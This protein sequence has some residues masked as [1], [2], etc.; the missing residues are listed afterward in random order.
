MAFKDVL[1]NLFFENEIEET[2]KRND[3]LQPFEKEWYCDTVVTLWQYQYA[4]STVASLLSSYLVNVDWTV[5]KQGER[6]KGDM[7][8]RLNYAPNKK[9]TSA[10]FFGKL[11][12]KLI[13]DREALIVEF[14][15]GQLFVA[16]QYEINEK[17]IKNS[18]FTNIMVGEY[19]SPLIR[20]FTENRDCIYVK[21]PLNKN[22]DRI[23]EM[24]NKNYG[25]ILALV[26]KGARKAMGMKLDLQLDAN[27]KNKYDEQTLRAL[28]DT[29]TKLMEKENALFIS[30]KGETLAD[31]TEKQ[32]GS[33]VQ[34]VLDLAKN[35][36]EVNQEILKT[37]GRAFGITQDIMTGDISTA[38]DDNYIMTMTQFT[39]PIVRMLDQKFTTY[40]IEKENIKAGTRIEGNLDAVQ[41]T[42]V[43]SK[44]TAI[45]KLIGS[46]AY[47]INEVR[48]KIGDDPVKDGDTRFITKN[49]S[50]LSEYVKGGE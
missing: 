48:E 42:D 2:R 24:M 35:N 16:D 33:E 10:D 50:V 45:D 34:Q 41:Y 38:N 32:R 46:G 30:Y 3:V 4:I 44:A 22:V 8:H 36:I 7:Y 25:E 18:T 12:N 17:S 39:K 47:T 21:L 6:L 14:A 26:K 40:F 31:L 23:F 29:Y 9:E 1:Q 19:G 49:Y 11:A 43:L 20:S 28:N 27:A 37:V 5:F 13:N 15:D